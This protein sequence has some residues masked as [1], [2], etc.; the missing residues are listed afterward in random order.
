MSHRLQKPALLLAAL[1]QLV[2]LARTLCTNPATGSTF[3]FILRWGI[4]AGAVLGSVDAVSAATS[5]F[6]SPATFTGQVGT[7]FSN[8]VVVSIGG[9]NKAAKDDYFILS[10]G[11]V[12]SPL[13]LNGQISTATL[14]PG[15][16][17]LAS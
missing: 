2:P 16:T 4:G 14:P 7:Y 3:A 9:G 11:A 1:L 5:V 17:F 12:T 6:T 13:L 10:A 8:N 15:L